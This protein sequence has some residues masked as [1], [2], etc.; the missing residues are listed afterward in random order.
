[1]KTNYRLLLVL[2]LFSFVSFSQQPGDEIEIQTI[3]FDGYP[4]GEGWLAP[5][6]GFFDF[7]SLEGLDFEKVYIKYKL[8]CD[9]TQNPNCGEWDYLSYLKVIEHT[10]KGL[11]PNY[12][13]G[14]NGG[15]TPESFSY[16]NNTAWSYSPRYEQSIVFDNPSSLSAYQ[17]GNGAQEIQDPFNASLNDSQTQYLFRQ[18][19]LVASGLTPGDITGMQF[20]VLDVGGEMQHLRIGIKATTQN[21][22][23]ENEIVTDFVEV[24]AKDY[25]FSGTGWQHIDFPSFFSW[26]GTS[27]IIVEVAFTGKEGA[28]PVLLS[29]EA[30]PWGCTSQAS[31]TDSYFNFNGP[32]KLGVPTS[33][34]TDIENEVTI[35]FWLN[36]NGEQPQSDSV[37]DVHDQDGNRVLNIHLPWSNQRVYWDAGDATG[38]DRIDKEVDD[39][40]QYKDV[41]N[42]WAF[43]KNATTGV[44]NIY[45]NAELWHTGSG[46]TRAV[47]NI[48]D[49]KLGRGQWSA[50]NFYDG[51]LDDFQIWST[52]LDQ[53]TIA[54]WMHKDVDA[55]HPNYSA[56]KANYKF[57]QIT[58]EYQ[59]LEEIS[60]EQTAL[61]GVP[62]LKSYNGSHFKN[63]TA[64]T[65]RPNVKFNRIS[66]TYTVTSELDVDS[67]A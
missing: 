29:G 31:Q 64:S 18:S 34:L 49:F 13:I 50:D 3:E 39:T 41:W 20:N 24:F 35:S 59:T 43:T 4:V 10:G 11:H 40:D 33:N 19:E 66:S 22:I 7:S 61:Y 62:Q 46:L 6:E 15:L 36:G 17:I 53:A 25:A 12:Y 9:P 23:Q 52:E 32:D 56:L 28:S 58:P 45:L 51:K 37:L 14:G 16:M 38:Y 8:K 60:N 63:F 21:E 67:I 57:D 30:Y 2:I 1:M 54:N 44:M 48:N 42:H 65:T 55:S 5:R 26:D 47:G 27:N